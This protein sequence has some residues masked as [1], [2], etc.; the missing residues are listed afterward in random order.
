MKAKTTSYTLFFTVFCLFFFYS[1][2]FLKAET[3]P[4]LWSTS[5]KTSRPTAVAVD[6]YEN[7]YIV[8]ASKNHLLVYNSSGKY[9]KKLDGLDK[10]I[11]LAVDNN[12]RIF[13]GNAGRGNVEVF[14]ADLTLLFKLGTGDGEFKQPTAIAVDSGGSIYVAD[15]KENK[16]KVYNS[17][18]YVS[19]YLTQIGSISLRL[20]DCIL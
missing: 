6:I 11:S 5:I 18:C 8:E 7:L 15:G 10:P 12:G 20:F 16:I 19:Q 14:K 4:D 13:I 2:T 9:L 3:I 1:L 17:N